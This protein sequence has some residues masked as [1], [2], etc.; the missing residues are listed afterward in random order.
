[1]SVQPAFIDVALPEDQSLELCIGFSWGGDATKEISRADSS[2]FKDAVL[3]AIKRAL[4][5]EESLVVAMSAEA[6]SANGYSRYRGGHTSQMVQELLDHAVEAVAK[7]MPLP[8]RC[9][10]VLV[11][12]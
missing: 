8:R 7:Q 4:E 9:D 11:T 1:M 5:A 12:R 2:A 6:H 3:V 10:A